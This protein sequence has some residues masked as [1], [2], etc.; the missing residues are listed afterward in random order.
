MKEGISLRIKENNRSGWYAN[1]N[2]NANAN[3]K[4]LRE[5]HR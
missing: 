4:P 3:A 2:A 1:A 5:L